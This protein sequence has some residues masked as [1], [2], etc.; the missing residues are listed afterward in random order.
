M[1]QAISSAT[2]FIGAKLPGFWRDQKGAV[3][4]EYLL[5]IAGVS[6][7]IIGAVA[8]GAPSLTSGVLN[9]TCSS[10]NSVFPTAATTMTCSF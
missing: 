10:I 2:T 9:A 7:A 5:V 8:V 6:V 3:A 4:W 1:I